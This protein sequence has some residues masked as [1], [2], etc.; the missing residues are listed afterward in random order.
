MTTLKDVAELA[1]VSISTVSR[2]LS[3]RGKISEETKER[4]LNVANELLFK[5]G[6]VQ[7]S[8][9]S[10]TYHIGLIIPD[11]GEYYHDDPA[12]SSD[13]RSLRD[14]FERNSH[15]SS[16]FFYSAQDAGTK[17]FRNWVESA[18]PDGIILSDPPSDGLL[19]A[20]VLGTGLPYLV[21]NGQVPGVEHNVVDYRNEQ[22]MAELVRRA[23]SLGHRRFL[24]LTGPQN[25]AVSQNRLTG[26][27]SAIEE[28]GISFDE[29][30]VLPGNFSI[31]S[32]YTRTAELI[33]GNTALFTCVVAFSDYIA[34]GAMKALKEAGLSVPKDVS[35]TG[36]DDIEIAKYSEPPLT[37]VRRFTPGYASLVTEELIRA[38]RFNEGIE[39]L[40]FWFKT[41]MVTRQSLVA[42]SPM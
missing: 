31:E 38:I 27:R 32:G 11:Q 14:S 20:E 25:R 24:L 6:A 28:A 36:F 18:Q 12:T 42:V 16:I 23:I 34:L 40:Q 7:N 19:L 33:R 3:N 1:G 2:V 29:Q 30:I 22:A 4:V 39:T 37:T 35:I 5:K 8:L 15:R 21:V 10:R 13:V 17:K 26:A 41:P 9:D